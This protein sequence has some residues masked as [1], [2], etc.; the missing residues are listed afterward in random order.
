MTDGFFIREFL[1]DARPLNFEALDGR[2]ASILDKQN[3]KYQT[4]TL[5]LRPN[6]LP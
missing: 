3:Q 4:K 6:S 1:S 2:D 5:S